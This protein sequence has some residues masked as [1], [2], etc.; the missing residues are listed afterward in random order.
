MGASIRRKVAVLVIWAV[1]ISQ[2]GENDQI[3]FLKG[4]Q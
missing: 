4:N 2:L 3:I 1:E